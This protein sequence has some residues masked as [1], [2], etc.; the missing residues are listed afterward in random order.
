MNTPEKKKNE[1]PEKRGMSPK[2]RKCVVQVVSVMLAIPALLAAMF[3]YVWSHNTGADLPETV[4][5]GTRP[6]PETKLPEKKK[7]NRYGPVHYS[8]DD[9]PKPMAMPGGKVVNVND[10]R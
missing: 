3:L 9:Y 8:S 2:D 6:E 4:E 1:K 5:P 10:P 7:L